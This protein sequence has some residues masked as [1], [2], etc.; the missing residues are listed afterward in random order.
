MRPVHHHELLLLRIAVPEVLSDVDYVEAVQS[1]EVRVR[2]G[3]L[4]DALCGAAAVEHGACFAR[5]DEAARLARG[6]DR[7]CKR[8]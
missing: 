7:D 3:L 1:G 6:L 4:E 5:M 2:V 8:G